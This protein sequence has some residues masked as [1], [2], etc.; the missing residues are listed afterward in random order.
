MARSVAGPWFQLVPLDHWAMLAAS[1]C[2]YV[3]HRESG[4]YSIVFLETFSPD[5]RRH[6]HEGAV[7]LAYS[8]E[9]DEVRCVVPVWTAD[10]GRLWAMRFAW[11]SVAGLPR[12]PLPQES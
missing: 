12:H 7:K 1:T 10:G 4:T 2:F 5:L 9:A 8:A 11:S 3:L 6:P